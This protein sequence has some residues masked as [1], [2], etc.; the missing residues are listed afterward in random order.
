MGNRF[1]LRKREYDLNK[2]VVFGK[3]K[4]IKIKRLMSLDMDYVEWM[5]RE[6]FI[7]LTNDALQ[8]MIDKKIAYYDFVNS[9]DKSQPLFLQVLIDKELQEI[10]NNNEF[11][12]LTE[13]K[14]PAISKMLKS[15][16]AQIKWDK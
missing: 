4:G 6:K 8:Y 3:Y 11:S 12:R 15:I 2:K 1:Y 5:L 10:K 7:Y 14:Q 16:K 9:L 13:Q